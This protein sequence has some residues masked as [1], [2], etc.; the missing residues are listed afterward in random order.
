M[1]LAMPTKKEK[2]RR[3]GLQREIAKRQMAQAEADRPISRSHLRDL[4]NYLDEELSAEGCDRSLRFTSRFIAK[5][6]LPE[7][8]II[9]WLDEYGGN[10]DCEVLAN[11]EEEWGESF[12]LRL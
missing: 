6:G 3:K 4:F 9:H 8:E 5:N 10:C 2:R 1:K 12:Q 11:V 7:E